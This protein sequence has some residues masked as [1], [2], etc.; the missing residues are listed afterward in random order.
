[1]LKSTR[2]VIAWLCLLISFMTVFVSVGYA[3]VI[4]TLTIA[5]TAD[6]QKEPALVYITNAKIVDDRTSNVSGETPTVTKIGPYVLT[7]ENSAFVL[8]RQTSNWNPGGTVTIEVAVKN[9]SGIK[10]YFAGYATDPVLPTTTVVTYEGMQPGDEIEHGGSRIF[11]IKIQ[12]AHTSNTVSF[13]GR[14]GF[15]N[16]APDFKEE[17]LENITSVFISVLDGTHPGIEHKGQAISGKNLLDYIYENYM[18]GK[19]SGGTGGYTGNVGNATQE[20]KDLMEAVFGDNMIME[21]GNQYYSV[22]FLL[23]HQDI[24]KDGIADMVLYFTPDSLETGGGTWKGGNNLNEGTQ[25]WNGLNIVPVYAL[26]F[27]RINGKYETRDHVFEGNAPVCAW[28]GQMDSNSIGN[29]NTNLWNS[30]EYPNLHD[31]NQ[32]QIS[33]SGVSRDGELDDAYVLVYGRG[34]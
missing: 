31:E 4:T 21:I 6:Y 9:N 32:S 10:Q 3:R 16:F 8:N 24:N 25:Y 19:E 27:P 2:A 12:N 29:F 13:E 17:T 11:W 33:Q 30:T 7:M 28:N 23:K 14:K 15:L 26:T 5:G 1:M 20:E 18:E 22:S 34:K